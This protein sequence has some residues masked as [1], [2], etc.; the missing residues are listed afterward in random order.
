MKKSYIKFAVLFITV[1][2]C[3]CF[4]GCKDKDKKSTSAV[5]KVTVDGAVSDEIKNKIDFD[6]YK[7]QK[8]YELS[9]KKESEIKLLYPVNVFETDT[10]DV[11]YHVEVAKASKKSVVLQVLGTDFTINK[12]VKEI[13]VEWKSV[14]LKV[15]PTEKVYEFKGLC[16]TVDGDVYFYED[17][18]YSPFIEGR[19]ITYNPVG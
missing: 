8:A 15:L 18:F 19:D 10:M 12:S 6:A 5:S 9:E 4:I 13:K 11:K 7:N 2:S 3:I 16:I 17:V 14:G 1:I